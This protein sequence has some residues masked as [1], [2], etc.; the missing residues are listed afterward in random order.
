MPNYYEEEKQRAI[1]A[2]NQRR[3][4]NQARRQSHGELSLRIEADSDGLHLILVVYRPQ[5]GRERDLVVLED[6]HWKVQQAT[7]DE[8]TSWGVRALMRHASVQLELPFE[9]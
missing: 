3:A 9:R 5:P 1:A 4:Q 6:V 8:I 2:A 7:E